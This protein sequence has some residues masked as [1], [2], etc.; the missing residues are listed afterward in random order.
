MQEC[1]TYFRQ[2]LDEADAHANVGFVLTQRGDFEA[3][4]QSY[5]KALSLNPRLKSAQHALL[6]L[7]EQGEKK[8]KSA[9]QPKEKSAETKT[10]WQR[11]GTSSMRS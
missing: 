8:Q 10:H 1:L 6:Q 9:P 7:A 2:Y 4:R 3:A 11:T 5:T